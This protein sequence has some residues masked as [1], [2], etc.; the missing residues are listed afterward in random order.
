MLIIKLLIIKNDKFTCFTNK[1]RKIGESHYELAVKFGLVDE[2]SVLSQLA[3]L[4]PTPIV[5][6]KCGLFF[7]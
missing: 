3:I 2:K 1:L 7:V 6:T 4:T 5:T